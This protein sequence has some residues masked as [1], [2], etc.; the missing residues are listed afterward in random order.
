[1]KR[2]KNSKINRGSLQIDIPAGQY[3]HSTLVWYIL[4][5]Y[6]QATSSVDSNL[7]QNVQFS[8][9]RGRISGRG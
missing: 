9:V 2:T 8:H 4:F 6:S 3:L 7:K 1:M 5:F